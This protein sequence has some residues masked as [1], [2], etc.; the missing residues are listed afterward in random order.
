MSPVLEIPEALCAYHGLYRGL[1][2]PGCLERQQ[3]EN[4]N[5]SPVLDPVL[6]V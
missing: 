6:P 3:T 2:C 1:E 4:E 5:R